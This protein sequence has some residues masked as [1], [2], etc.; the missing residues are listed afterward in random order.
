[1]LLK[2]ARLSSNAYI[3]CVKNGTLIF[4]SFWSLGQD[5]AKKIGIVC[6]ESCLSLIML[7]VK[8]GLKTA[9]FI[10]YIIYIQK[11]DIMFYILMYVDIKSNVS[12]S[13]FVIFSHP[14]PVGGERKETGSKF[15]LPGE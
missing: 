10:F 4:V 1:M 15:A 13:K 5:P 12:S 2:V 11:P 7:E 14:P 3:H 9:K 6:P 8:I